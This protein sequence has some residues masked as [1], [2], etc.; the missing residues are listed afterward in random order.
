MDILINNKRKEYPAISFGSG[1]SGLNK[2]VK[3]LIPDIGDGARLTLAV[4]NNQLLLVKHEAGLK[5]WAN[6]ISS[7]WSNITFNHVKRLNL[8]WLNMDKFR[9][10]RVFRLEQLEQNVFKIVINQETE[11]NEKL[12]RP[13]K[14]GSRQISPHT[15]K[16][17]KKLCGYT[18]EDCNS[19]FP[20]DKGLAVHHILPLEKGG[21]DHIRNLSVLCAN[22]HAKKH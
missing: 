21:S 5:T 17:I 4:D 2:Y 18:C 14:Q 20:D 11:Q 13:I 12:A 22:C 6:G 19:V 1:M 3:D 10:D 7:Y 8:S 9:A 16:A 15:I